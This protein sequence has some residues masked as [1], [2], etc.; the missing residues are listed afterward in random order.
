MPS[1]G[2]WVC[3]DTIDN[4]TCDTMWWPNGAMTA[5]AVSGLT[6]GTYY[7]QVRTSDGGVLADNGAWHAFTVS[8]PALFVKQAPA[9][10]A[11]GLGSTV[12]LQWTAVP[13][14]GYW[15]CWDTSDN[16]ACDTTWWPNGAA[17]AKVLS[18]LTSGTYY[19][20]VRTSDGG[21]LADNGAW[22]AFT[23]STTALFTKQT[24]ANGATGLGSTV[25]LQ[26][27]AVPDEGYWVCWDTT[28]NGTCDTTWWPNGAMTAKRRQ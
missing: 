1:E 21:V 22:H 25:T 15:V 23:V 11:T 4:D 10:G 14:E 6:S 18:G 2:Y 24:P 9:N 27:T 8:A 12:T 26:W 13:D 7:W 28:D 20:Q 5:K 3:W 19:W 16:G 17:T